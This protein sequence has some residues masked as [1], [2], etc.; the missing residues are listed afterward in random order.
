MILLNLCVQKYRKIKL[1]IYMAIWN[2]KGFYSN[3]GRIFESDYC[4]TMMMRNAG[5]LDMWRKGTDVSN[6]KVVLNFQT[7]FLEP[8]CSID[9]PPEFP[10]VLVARKVWLISSHLHPPTIHCFLW[11]HGTSRDGASRRARPVYKQ[12]RRGIASSTVL[13]IETDAYFDRRKNIIGFECRLFRKKKDTSTK[14]IV[15]DNLREV[16]G[17]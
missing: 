10:E 11:R 15:K 16:S 12:A 17:L 9:F 5:S 1:A 2:K 4:L 3:K 7:N 14:N 13:W 8:N 6:P